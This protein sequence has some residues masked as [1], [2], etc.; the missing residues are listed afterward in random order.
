MFTRKSAWT[1]SKEFADKLL[2][3]E[4]EQR[5]HRVLRHCYRGRNRFRLRLLL[6]DVSPVAS[7][8]S[9]ATFIPTRLISGVDIEKLAY[10]TAS[11]VWRAGVHRWVIDEHELKAIDIRVDHLERLRLF[12]MGETG[13]P[14]DTCLWVSIADSEDSPLS[15]VVCP[16]YGGYHDGHYSFRFLI[17]GIM[18]ALF[19]GPF[20][21]EIVHQLCSVRSS[22]RFIHL[23]KNI[24]TMTFQYAVEFYENEPA[25]IIPSFNL[26]SL[27]G[28]SELALKKPRT[29]P[30]GADVELL[31][32]R[33]SAI[34]TSVLCG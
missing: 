32:A 25:V 30:L 27:L 8:I 21:P 15:M 17:P 2:C 3:M 26:N 23:T 28:T 10:F 24:E 11:V 16:P 22:D 33:F 19:I 29:P 5:F 12:L 18:F 20:M 14:S 9:A 34:T 1:S 6:S 13:F 7:P 31:R 4:C